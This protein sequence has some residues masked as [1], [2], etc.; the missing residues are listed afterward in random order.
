MI[1][2]FIGEN[3]KGITNA[4]ILRHNRLCPTGSV[5]SFAGSN[6]PNGW[7]MCQ[8]Q[9]VNISVYSKLYDTIGTTYGVADLAGD[10]RLP[11]LRSR[12]PVGAGDGGDGL[13]N[14]VLG[15]TGGAETHTLTSDEMPSHSHGVND[16]GH[17]HTT[18]IQDGDQSVNTLT[19]QDA[20]A[21]ENEIT[22]NTSLATTGITI[23]STGD[24]LP[25]NNMQPFIVLNYI[26][27]Y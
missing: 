13:T 24:G 15:A 20:A 19:T 5:T 25:H 6:A 10:F 7:L 1:T 11:D 27:K 12:I 4:L 22:V 8:G 18:S 2:S 16:P 23:N 17:I 3:S 21:S 9:D 26:I 14:R